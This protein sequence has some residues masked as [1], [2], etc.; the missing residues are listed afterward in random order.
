VSALYHRTQTGEGQGVDVSMADSLFSLLFDEPLDCYGRL[1]LAVQQGNRIMRF[2]PFNTYRTADGW[3]TIGC[4][5][6]TEWSAL[7]A[8][9]DGPPAPHFD[10]V[11]GR[12]ANNAGIDRLVGNWTRAL[13]SA[14]VRTSTDVDVNHPVPLL[15]LEGGQ[16]RQRHDAG[17]VDQDVDPIEFGIGKIHEGLH[18]FPVDDVE[19]SNANRSDLRCNGFRQ[20]FQAIDPAGAEHGADALPREVRRRRLAEAARSPDDR[21]DFSTDIGHECFLAASEN[22][23][24]QGA[25]TDFIEKRRRSRSPSTREGMSATN[26]CMCGKAKCA[27]RSSPDRQ[28]S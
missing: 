23:T 4:T 5:T 13:T 6:D 18:I 27:S 22:Q 25:G 19:R 8:T 28:F 26:A 10:K 24:R 2:S 12:L 21:N 11:A 9:I 20:G 17:I 3:V 16:G 7:I 15:D 14:E 1:G